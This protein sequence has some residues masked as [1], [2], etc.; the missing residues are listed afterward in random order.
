MTPSTRAR[1]APSAGQHVG[2]LRP[3]AGAG[4][5]ATGLLTWPSAATLARLLLAA[6]EGGGGG[7]GGVGSRIRGVKV[8]KS[9]GAFRRFAKICI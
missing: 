5:D 3:G 2:A 9:A 4:A 8:P 6:R 7:G 1:S